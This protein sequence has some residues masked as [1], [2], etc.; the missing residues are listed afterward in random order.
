MQKPWNTRTL[1]TTPPLT[2]VFLISGWDER[3]RHFLAHHVF[4]LLPLSQPPH[5][6]HS[7][8]SLCP[9]H[10]GLLLPVTKPSLVLCPL[11]AVHLPVCLLHLLT[12]VL[13]VSAQLNPWAW[14]L[15]LPLPPELVLLTSMLV[16]GVSLFY[17]ISHSG[18]PCT[19]VSFTFLRCCPS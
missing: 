14:W 2:F 8:H 18:H 17:F 19:F 15:S 10:T 13:Q 5:Q 3:P 7:A 16:T 6:P 11:P 4:S 12:L 1:I 9:G